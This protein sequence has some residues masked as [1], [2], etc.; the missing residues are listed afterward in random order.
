RI[1]VSDYL[2]NAVSVI[3]TLTHRVIKNITVGNNPRTVAIT[4]DG[5]E[6]YVTNVSDGTVSVINNEQLAVVLPAI[7]TGA[8]GAVGD[9]PW[10]LTITPDGAWAY[11][12]NSG[13]HS[14]SVSIIDTSTHAVV[15]TLNSPPVGKGPFFSVVDPSGAYLY[16]SNSEDT[17][18]SVIDLANQTVSTTIYNVGDRPFELLCDSPW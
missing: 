8:G 4:P 11:V 10:Q 5:R 6:I 18:V 12:S 14:P 2:G 16:V 17:S 1:L 13:I 7:P 15:N 9:T 3:D